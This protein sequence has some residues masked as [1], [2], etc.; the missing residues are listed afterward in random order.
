MAREMR[1]NL[2]TRYEEKVDVLRTSM[3]HL[4]L[5]LLLLLLLMLLVRIH[6]K[7]VVRVC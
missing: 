4:L 5:L 3:Y 6:L 7:V 2:S 1:K